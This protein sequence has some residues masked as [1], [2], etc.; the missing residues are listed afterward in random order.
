VFDTVNLHHSTL[1]RLVDFPTPLTP[2]NTIVYG[3]PASR[4][5]R[6]QGLTLVHF[7]AQLK[8]FL[9]DKGYM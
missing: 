8:R 7:S 4:A 6:T 5:A 2:T 9:L 3:R 1:L